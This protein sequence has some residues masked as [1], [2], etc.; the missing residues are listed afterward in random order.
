MKKEKI[1]STRDVFMPYRVIFLF[2]AAVIMVIN[3][4]LGAFF[5]LDDFRVLNATETTMLWVLLISGGVV[6]PFGVACLFLKKDG[7]SFA[8]SL[9][10]SAVICYV[11]FYLYKNVSGLPL[12]TV[13]LYQWTSLILPLYMGIFWAVEA[14][15]IKAHKKIVFS[16]TER[17]MDEKAPSILD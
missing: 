16:K 15:Y 9:L 5:L 12:S 13:A 1:E 8:A 3:A 7:L 10:S 14:K 2:I 4:G 6:I 17:Q 11:G